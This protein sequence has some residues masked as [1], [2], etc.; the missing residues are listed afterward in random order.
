MSPAVLFALIGYL[1]GSIPFGLLLTRA[2]G[3]G[4]LRR[5]GSGNIGATNVLRTGRKGLA[6]ATL[7]LDGAKGAAAVLLARY[8]MGSEHVAAIAGFAAFGGHLFPLW[9]G[10]RGGKGVATMLGVSL[11]GW[12][13]AGVVA[14]AV[15]LLAALGTRY[16]SVGGMAAALASAVLFT[17]GRTAVPLD[18]AWTLAAWAMA[19]LLVL[20]HSDNIRRLRAGTERRIGAK[21]TS[22]T[23]ADAAPSPLGHNG[24]PALDPHEGSR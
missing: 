22:A 14:L 15:W 24:G 21:T 12:W 9:L 20:K 4:D 1:L 17:V 10:F 8:A 5:I 2:F 18:L 7:V 6:A 19:A 23:S 13:P 3:A 11:A 16:S